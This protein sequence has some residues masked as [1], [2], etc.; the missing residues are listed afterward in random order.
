M[1]AS[2]LIGLPDVG[3]LT[4]GGVLIRKGCPSSGGVFDPFPVPG[5]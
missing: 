3:S 4:T 2:R 5:I 1:E